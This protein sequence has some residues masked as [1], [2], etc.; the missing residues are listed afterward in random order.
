MRGL[1]VGWEILILYYNVVRLPNQVYERVNKKTKFTFV[2]VRFVYHENFDQE[3]VKLFVL[4]Q[5][6]TSTLPKVCLPIT[7]LSVRLP[8]VCLQKVSLP[9]QVN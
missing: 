7:S 9:V 3:F 6:S 1:N 8:K 5:N 4:R 2:Y